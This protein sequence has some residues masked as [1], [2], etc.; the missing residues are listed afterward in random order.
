M[1]EVVLT[2]VSMELTIPIAAYVEEVDHIA[3]KM[4]LMNQI[5]VIMEEV[6]LGAA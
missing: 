6:E 3:V 4:V 2:V 1:E 5:A